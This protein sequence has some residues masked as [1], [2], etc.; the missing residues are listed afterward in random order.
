MGVG[1]KIKEKVSKLSQG[2][3]TPVLGMALD[4]LGQ[5]QPEGPKSWHCCD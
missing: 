5:M 1:E 3:F 4:M 2:A